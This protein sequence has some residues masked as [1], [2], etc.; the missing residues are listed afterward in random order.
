MKKLGLTFGAIAITVVTALSAQ[1]FDFTIGRTLSGTIDNSDSNDKRLVGNLTNHTFLA[2][3]EGVLTPPSIGDTD[4]NR[5]VQDHEGIWRATKAEETRFKGARRE[6]N[7]WPVVDDSD[8]PTTQSITLTAAK[9]IVVAKG[10]GTVTL[11]GTGSGILSPSGLTTRKQLVFTPTAGS[12]SFT[13]SGTVTEIAV[14]LTEG[15]ILDETAPEYV[16]N[17]TDYGANVDG[18]KYFNTENG[19]SVDGSNIVTE[20]TGAY[21]GTPINGLF[22]EGAATNLINQPRDL[23]HANWVNSGGTIGKTLDAVGID[24]QPNTATTLE[25]DDGANYETII[26]DVTIPADTNPVLYSVYVKKDS[27]ESRFF[28]LQISILTTG[29]IGS[30]WLNTSTGAT[31]VSNEV[32]ANSIDSYGV[33]D[34]GDWWEVWGVIINNS[35]TAARMTLSPAFG[36]VWGTASAAATGSAIVDAASIQTNKTYP[37][38]PLLN[39]GGHA[40]LADIEATLDINNFPDTHGSMEFY[41]TPEFDVDVNAEGI[42][43]PNAIAFNFLYYVGAT[44]IIRIGD[45]LNSVSTSAGQWTTGQTIHVKARWNATTG[46]MNISVDGVSATEGTFDGSFSP[47]GAIT[48]FKS[49]TLGASIKNLKIYRTDKGEAWLSE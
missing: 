49:L 28:G 26:E 17:Q 34:R 1:T 37:T 4:G 13:I 30:V 24:G 21:I 32:P 9:H 43:T 38:S 10:T 11:G 25:D 15:R 16:H 18:V 42:I 35:G 46:K 23:T 2:K 29:K 47:S 5:L 36:T 12:V 8:L 44:E 31:T 3:G 45:G 27:D 6:H 19:N 7:L 22:M 39:T 20:G 33:I 41:L 40:R 14:Y 48:L